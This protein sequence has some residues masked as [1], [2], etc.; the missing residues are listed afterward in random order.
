MRKSL[1]AVLAL[2]MLLISCSEPSTAIDNEEPDSTIS[3]E[4]ILKPTASSGATAVSDAI[5]VENPDDVIELIGLEA[6]QLYSIYIDKTKVSA[7]S[8]APASAG[9]NAFVFT[10]PEGEST[11]KFSAKSVGLEAGQQFRIGKITAPAIDFVDGTSHMEI[12]QGV[13]EPL[14]TQ[15]DGQEYYEGYF[16]VD[17]S[18]LPSDLRLDEVVLLGYRIGTGSIGASTNCGIVD[19]TGKSLGIKDEGI[20]DLS[21]YDTVYV[22]ISFLLRE[23]DEEGQSYGVQ[24]VNPIGITAEEKIVLKAPGVYKINPTGNQYLRV[25]ANNDFFLG[26]T[27]FINDL[28]ARYVSDGMRH[29]RF[30]PVEVTNNAM[31]LNIE[32]GAEPFIFNYEQDPDDLALMAQLVDVTT[33]NE[34]DVQEVTINAEGETTF[35]MEFESDERYLPVIFKGDASNLAGCRLSYEGELP[36][37][38]KAGAGHANGLGYSTRSAKSTDEQIVFDSDQI[39]EYAFFIRNGNDYPAGSIKVTI[40]H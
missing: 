27:A 22:Y 5:S 15:N 6:G 10:V 13:T 29:P 2:F 30:F 7:K 32:K 35:T 12:G 23:A 20:I 36:G 1:L 17:V 16:K 14:Y 3:I 9:K 33:E 19:E 37:M 28:A 4:D 40:S 11:Y 21:D 18:K 26:W 34:V 8:L 24:L 31:L 25:S 38:L 39:I